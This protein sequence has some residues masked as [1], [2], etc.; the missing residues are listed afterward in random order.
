MK[1]ERVL[2]GRGSPPDEG[3]R[4]IFRLSSYF[5]IGLTPSNSQMST[6]VFTI[7][8]ALLLDEEQ[9]KGQL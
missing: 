6:I 7:M 5:M 3:K 1:G 4:K 2:S 8:T 9:P